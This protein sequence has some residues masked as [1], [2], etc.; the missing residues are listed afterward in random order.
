M[1]ASGSNDP[2][3]DPM[4]AGGLED[5]DDPQTVAGDML[6][7]FIIELKVRG[8]ISAADACILAYWSAN[9]G[10]VGR[11]REMGMAPGSQST[12]HYSRRFD[13]VSGIDTHDN[14]HYVMGA[15]QYLACDGSRTASPLAT[16]PVHEALANE[17]DEDEDFHA[18]LA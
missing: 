10:A 3:A 14:K 9:A 7:Q 13:R 16:V 18:K 6:L 2:V 4:V 5:T 15:P 17:I 8:K 11:V 12:G 1:A